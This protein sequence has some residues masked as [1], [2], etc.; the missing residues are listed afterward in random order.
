MI[1]EDKIILTN[2]LEEN[3]S[4]VQKHFNIQSDTINQLILG[5]DELNGKDIEITTLKSWNGL[6]K[7]ELRT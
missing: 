5:N 2:T 1:E 3:I 6:L 7:N 4:N